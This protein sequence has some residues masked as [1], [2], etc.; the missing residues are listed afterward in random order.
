MDWGKL[1]VFHAVARSGSFTAA[2]KS[3]KLSQSAVSRQIN[4]L[5]KSLGVILFHRHSRGLLLTAQGE[6]LNETAREV[7]AK[8][9][10]AEA[11]LS[12][13]RDKPR[14][15]LAITATLAFASI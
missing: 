12:E 1:K 13:A 7:A 10:M 6:A 9:T 15:P 11:N 8:L 14:G 5:E 2:G 4:A 3:L